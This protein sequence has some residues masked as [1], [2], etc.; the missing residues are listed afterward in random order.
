M[1]L[2]LTAAS[3]H[4]ASTIRTLS[5][6][7][8]QQLGDDVVAML[9]TRLVWLERV[10]LE[11]CSALSVD[12]LDSLGTHPSLR[13]CNLEGCTRFLGASSQLGLLGVDDLL[14]HPGRLES[15]DY[16]GLLHRRQP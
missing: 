5:L 16:G 9:L 1:G 10:D 2:T 6:R 15:V 13:H 4:P 11:G 3:V 12:V 14:E 7:N 8:A